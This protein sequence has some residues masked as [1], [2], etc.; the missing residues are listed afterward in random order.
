M[1]VIVILG[2]TRVSQN[3]KAVFSLSLKTKMARLLI[4][5]KGSSCMLSYVASGMTTLTQDA[6]PIT[7]PLWVPLFMTS[8]EIYSRKNF[9]FY[10]FALGDGR[11]WASMMRMAGEGKGEGEMGGDDNDQGGQGTMTRGR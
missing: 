9:H 3:V 2:T 1:I 11:L 8:S 10:A 6:L 4:T 7:G 5:V